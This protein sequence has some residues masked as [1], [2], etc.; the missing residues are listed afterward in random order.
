MQ[1]AAQTGRAVDER[2]HLRKDGSTFYCS[3]V[4]TPLQS[5]D[6]TG[7][8]K[9]AR[10]ITAFKLDHENL[11][12]K[13]ASSRLEANVANELKDRL[14]AVVSHELKQPLNLI[15]INTELLMRAPQTKD[16]RPRCELHRSYS[17]RSRRKLKSSTTCSTC[18][19]FD[20]Q[21]AFE[22]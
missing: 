2:W 21:A 15:R 7:Y 16:I 1:T 20:R 22:H 8:A 11:V 6:G 5:Q 12:E 4:L 3:G 18:L 19:A 14:L 10:D 17:A 9:I 13:E